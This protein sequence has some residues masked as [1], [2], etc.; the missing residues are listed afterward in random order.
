MILNMLIACMSNTMT[1]VTENVLVE[2]TFGRTEVRIIKNNYFIIK[3]TNNIKYVLYLNN[4]Y[5]KTLEF[6]NM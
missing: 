3:K 1:K 2:W 5:I 4:N 6:T